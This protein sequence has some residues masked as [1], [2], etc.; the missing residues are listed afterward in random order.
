M[1]PSSLVFF[2]T[3]AYLPQTTR[4][5]VVTRPRSETLTSMIVPL[6]MTPRDVYI[7][8]EGFF[9]TPIMSR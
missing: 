6:V 3:C 7:V 4:P 2:V 1:Q 8:L 9:L 5:V